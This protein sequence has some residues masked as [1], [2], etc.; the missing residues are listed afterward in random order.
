MVAYPSNQSPSPT[1]ES[2]SSGA[3]GPI[4]YFDDPN[5]ILEGFIAFI[6]PASI[7]LHVQFLSTSLLATI[8]LG[9]GS[10]SSKNR[11]LLQR[12]VQELLSKLSLVIA[13]QDRVT[14][15]P[16]RKSTDL[17]YP[18]TSISLYPGPPGLVN[19]ST[20]PCPSHKNLGI[21]GQNSSQPFPF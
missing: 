19:C 5:D 8:N 7:P 2:R 1:M 17:W 6:L 10:F 3:T 11:C 9:I 21:S 12:Q 16:A 14:R 13:P 18:L 15:R 4:F 20:N